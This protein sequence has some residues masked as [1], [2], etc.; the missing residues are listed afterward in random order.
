MFLRGVNFEDLNLHMLSFSLSLS[1]KWIFLTFSKK[2]MPRF[3]WA[4]MVLEDYFEI[5]STVYLLCN[6]QYF[7]IVLYYS[8]V[9]YFTAGSSRD[10]EPAMPEALLD[11]KH[12]MDDWRHVDTVS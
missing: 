5:I 2:V 12:E 10:G 1:H 9:C 6:N 8:F 7:V 4:L 11:N 3:S